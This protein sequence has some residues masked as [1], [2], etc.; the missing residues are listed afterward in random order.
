MK[1]NPLVIEALK[2]AASMEAALATQY[3][4]DAR[5]AKYMR[6]KSIAKKLCG[7]GEDS[8]CYLK[9]IVDRILYLGAKPEYSAGSAMMSPTITEIFQ[10]SLGDEAT[11]VAFYNDL[12][13]LARSPSIK[14]DNS[15]NIAEHM[16][17]W[18][19]NR[20]IDWLEGQLASIA[21]LGEQN[22]LTIV[23]EV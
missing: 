19:E 15:G 20:N 2:K 14:D 3:R 5:D 1:G 16:V 17:K 4:L 18:H 22:Y 21:T 11:I 6:L 9:Q 8:E 13:I 23:V 12:A 10:A 7:F